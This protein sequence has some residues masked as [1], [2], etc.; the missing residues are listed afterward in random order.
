MKASTQVSTIPFNINDHLIVQN[1]KGV[2]SSNIII[3]LELRYMKITYQDRK[4]FFTDLF[5]LS[6]HEERTEQLLVHSYDIRIAERKGD[7][8][9]HNTKLVDLLEG[10]LHSTKDYLLA[11]QSVINIPEMKTYLEKN[12]L[13][14]PMDYP[15]QKNVRRAILHR[16]INGEQSGIP[17]QILTTCIFK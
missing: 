15:G 5:E 8:S 13:A 14:A 12:I 9:M 4:I 10:N 6:T 17:P 3:Q 11:V 1:P 2:D 16:M 7:R